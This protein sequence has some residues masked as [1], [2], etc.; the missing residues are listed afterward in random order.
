MLQL[1]LALSLLLLA[2][3]PATA[4]GTSPVQDHFSPHQ[5]FRIQSRTPNAYALYSR[6]D[7]IKPFTAPESR[8]ITDGIPVTGVHAAALQSVGAQSPAPGKAD[9]AAPR[10]SDQQQ[11]KQL[12]GHSSLLWTALSFLGLGLLLA[13]TPCVLPMIPILTGIIAG[14]GKQNSALRGFVL[15]G[16][17]VLAMAVAYTIFGVIAGLAGENLQASLQAPPAIALF[18]AL[19]VLL[20][21]AMFGFYELQ[22]P[23]AL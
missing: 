8:R 17:Y 13:F 3:L 4:A 2:C 9:N 7:R 12:I 1:S 6:Q 14:Q 22:L 5:A 15:S 11:L 19:F 10:M 18:S 21:L 16:V 20:A 23:S